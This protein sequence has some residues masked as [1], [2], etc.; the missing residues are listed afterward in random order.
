MKLS[1]RAVQNAGS[2]CRIRMRAYTHF[3]PLRE[4]AQQNDNRASGTAFAPS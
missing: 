1:R 2:E 3:Q 4:F